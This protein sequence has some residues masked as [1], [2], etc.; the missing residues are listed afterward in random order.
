MSSPFLHPPAPL[1]SPD[2]IGGTDSPPPIPI[3]L[4]GNLKKRLETL[5]RRRR[6]I[7]ASETIV[8]LAS[9]LCLAWLAQSAADWW[10]P[11]PWTVRA[12]FLGAD[13]TL[14]GWIYR[15]YFAS[16]FRE[17]SSLPHV[18]LMVEKKWPDL[19]QSLIS[20]VELAAGGPG[21]T[22]GSYPLVFEVLDLAHERTL[23]LD[24]NEVV[25]FRPFLRWLL[26]GAIIAMGAMIAIAAAWPMSLLLLERV[27]LSPVPQTV[28]V[29][30]TKDLPLAVGSDV[31]LSVCTTG[32]IPSGGRVIIKYV[33]VPAKEV[34]IEATPG[35]PGLFT[36]A[37]TN[38]QKPFTYRFHLNDGES[39]EFK[40]DAEVPPTI[41]SLDFMVI[42]PDYTGFAPEIRTASNLTILAGSRLHLVAT[43]TQAVRS[44]TIKLTGTPGPQAIEMKLDASG[45]KWVG[46]IP[47]PAKDLT[48]FFI[49]LV[50][51]SG[52]PSMN[53]TVYSIYPMPDAPPEVK[54]L[55]PRLERET[56]V[57]HAMPLIVC[58]ASDNFG[59]EKL[60]LKFQRVPPAVKGQPGQPLPVEEIPLSIDHS[61]TAHVEY[62]LNVSRQSPAWEEGWTV[63]YWIEAVDNNSVTGPGVAS[64]KHQH[65]SLVTTEAKEA[66]IAQRLKQAG[67]TLDNLSDQQDKL[68]NEANGI[69]H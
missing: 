6:L 10:V 50:T 53:E 31:T 8:V 25:P 28:V 15:R 30:I 49:H 35:Q 13:V 27:L 4:P 64:S 52:F 12:L 60:S 42:Y 57:L 5:R 61:K 63:D 55:E 1:P 18:A 3:H 56:I 22:R 58:E 62:T 33:G 29:P 68:S 40:V 37:M 51:T 11:L 38:V 26:L 34:P 67:R 36:L 9:L 43:A 21:T 66:E 48:G 45:E 14:L 39:P 16:G 59:L 7:A 19:H 44:A 23:H 69:N 47:I 46:E 54:L 65:F 20:A 2:L 24:F 41:A 32:R 17:A